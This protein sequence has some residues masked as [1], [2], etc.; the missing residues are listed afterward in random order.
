VADAD[1]PTNRRRAGD[2]RPTSRP[3]VWLAAMIPNALTPNATLNCGGRMQ[4]SSS[5]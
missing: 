4:D 2:T 1:T 5:G 3:E